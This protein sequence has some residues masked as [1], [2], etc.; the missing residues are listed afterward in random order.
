MANLS[1]KLIV[2]I[3]FE[4]LSTSQPHGPASLLR[5]ISYNSNSRPQNPPSPEY[6]QS[7]KHGSTNV[8]PSSWQRELHD[9]SK[10]YTTPVKAR[11]YRTIRAQ[12]TAIRTAKPPRGAGASTTH[13]STSLNPDTVSMCMAPTFNSGMVL[14]LHLIPA[15]VLVEASVAML[16]A[17]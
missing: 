4:H 10:L 16:M 9:K 1:C 5:Q 11:A 12:T 14:G 2:V 17:Q 6:T 15:A 13:P 3:C 7:V 8:L